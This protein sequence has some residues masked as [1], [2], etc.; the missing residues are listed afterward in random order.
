MAPHNV[1]QTLASQ[2]IACNG[3]HS[4]KGAAEEGDVGTKMSS[5]CIGVQGHGET[6]A[7]GAL[8]ADADVGC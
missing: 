5:L 1:Q 7:G 4:G 6:V 2:G 8:D 3:E